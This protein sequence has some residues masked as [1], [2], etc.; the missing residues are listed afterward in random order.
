MNCKK[1]K[2]NNLYS[3]GNGKK[4]NI[5]AFC[6]FFNVWDCFFFDYVK[7]SLCAYFVRVVL[8]FFLVRF[9]R[10][11]VFRSGHDL[12]SHRHSC[13]RIRDGVTGD[14]V[15]TIVGGR[16]GRKFVGCRAYAATIRLCKSS[17]R[18]V[19]IGRQVNGQK[20]QKIRKTR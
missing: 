7:V 15:R 8:M 2:L 17:R 1:K 5:S 10:L 12:S 3:T 9:C 4:R 6:S 16:A 18:N 11:R 14:F 13:A 20:K 19:R